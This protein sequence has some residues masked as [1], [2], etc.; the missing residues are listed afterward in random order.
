MNPQV[1]DTLEHQ[2]EYC[3]DPHMY[4]GCIYQEYNGGEHYMF[5]QVGYHVFA[6]INL[7]EGNRLH[8]PVAHS[9]AEHALLRIISQLEEPITMVAKDFESF[10]NG[11]R[12]E[13]DKF[14]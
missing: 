5:C 14:I 9:S 2:S 11:E 12:H 10:I 8:D 13:R 7:E 6:L 1:G 4:E 3:K